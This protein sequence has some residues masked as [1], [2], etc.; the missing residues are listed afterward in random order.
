MAKRACKTCRRIVE[1]TVCPVCKTNDTTSN[2]QGIV[3]V[4]DPASE[5]AQKLKI[6]APGKYAIKV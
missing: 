3:F 5:I 1:K 4:F 2:F 6:T